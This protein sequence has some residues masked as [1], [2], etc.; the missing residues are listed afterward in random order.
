MTSDATMFTSKTALVKPSV[1][2]TADNSKLNV[3]H[4]GDISSA[5]LSVSDT[6]LVPQLTLNLLSVSQLCEL[7]FG[8]Y[9][10]DHGWVVQDP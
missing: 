8:V 1:I 4:T 3:S 5:H 2:H 10:S 6:F 9:F 7:G